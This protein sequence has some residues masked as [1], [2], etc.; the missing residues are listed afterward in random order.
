V[1][2]LRRGRRRDGLVAGLRGRRLRG[3]APLNRYFDAGMRTRETRFRGGAGR[4]VLDDLSRHVGVLAKRAATALS[5]VG[6]VCHDA[7][8]YQFGAIAEA[9]QDPS[10]TM[11][12]QPGGATGPSPFRSRPAP[13]YRVETGG[14]DR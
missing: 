9:P 10:M 2:N 14:V 4:R 13:H 11:D 8:D 6:V 7:A 3:I 1:G 12:P 5:W